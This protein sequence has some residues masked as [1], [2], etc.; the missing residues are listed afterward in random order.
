MLRHRVTC[1]AFTN[2]KDLSILSYEVKTEFFNR[3]N[4]YG[5]LKNHIT[6]FQLRSLVVCGENQANGIFYPSAYS[7][8]HNLQS[9]VPSMIDVELADYHSFFKI[10]RMMPDEKTPTDTK[11]L[12]CILDSSQLQRSANSRVSSLAC[13]DKLLATGT[14]EGGL[15]MHSLEDALHPSFLGELQ[16]SKSTDG[17][18]N[19]ITIEKNDTIL[20]ASNDF[21]LRQLDIR[22]S[23]LRRSMS[24]PF[25]IN[26]LSVNPHNPNEY[27]I[28]ADSTDNFILDRRCLKKD[29][30]T[31]SAR[32]RGHKDYGFS[33]DWS[34]VDEN[35]LV[36][37]NQDGTV[38]LWDRRKT[39]ESTFVWNSALGSYAFDIDGGVLGGPVRNCKFGHYGEHIVWAESLDHVGIV[40]TRDLKRLSEILPRVQSIDFIGK[41]IG[42]NLGPTENG[43][44]ESLIIGVNDCPL[45]GILSYHL[46]TPDKPLPFDFTF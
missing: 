24:L 5:R 45:G 19:H 43:R 10:I 11:K 22:K 17:I 9:V 34:P 42:L 3:K 46:E 14:F 6:H 16:I 25:A 29:H 40:S 39:D 32:F 30:F 36:S 41:C 27:F 18:T 7:L 21:K 13:S 31:T 38:R 1:F 35:L 8:D 4:F 33:C 28:A 44:D 23:F 12:D 2:Q 15:I 37:G 20:V 26:C